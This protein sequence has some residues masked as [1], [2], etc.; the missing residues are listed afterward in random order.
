MRGGCEMRGRWELNANPE[1][2]KGT[3][4][5]QPPKTRQHVIAQ[6]RQLAIEQL[7]HA[8]QTI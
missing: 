2:E 4:E 6:L 7:H 3:R 5:Q 8:K 1:V